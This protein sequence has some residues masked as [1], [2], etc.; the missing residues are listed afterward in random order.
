MKRKKRHYQIMRRT[1]W[2]LWR[3]Y[4]ESESRRS[5]LMRFMA[6]LEEGWEQYQ[7]SNNQ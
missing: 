3:T 2:S 4:R 1:R 6:D 5:R 7:L